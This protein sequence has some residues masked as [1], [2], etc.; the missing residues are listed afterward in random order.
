MA[1][2]TYHPPHMRGEGGRWTF[3]LSPDRPFR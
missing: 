1:G 2:P 3:T